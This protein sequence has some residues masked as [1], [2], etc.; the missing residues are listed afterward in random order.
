MNHVVLR[1]PGDRIAARFSRRT[2][3]VVLSLGVVLLASVFASLCL[4]SRATPPAAVLEA[5]LVPGDGARSFIVNELRLPRVVL[6]VLVGAAFAVAGL[7]LQALVRNPLASPD[8]IGVTGGGSVAAVVFLA[9]QGTAFPVHRL[10]PVA[11]TGAA[12]SA[13]L[14]VALAWQRGVTPTRLVLIGVG[15]AAAMGAVTTLVMVL[16]PDTTTL[17]AYVWLIGSLYAAQWREVQGIVPWFAL[18]LPVALFHA[19]HMDALALGDGVAAGLGVNVMRTRLVVLSASVVL[20]GAAVAFAGG[21]G[22]V[23][24][25]APHI[26]RRLTRG[27]SRVAD[28]PGCCWSP[29]WWAQ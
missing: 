17:Q 24:L 9:V 16:N 11:M 19:R 23:G 28:T 12:A 27:G 1:S 3:A 7:L 14:I 15:I 29:P 22:F 5:L 8:V 26:A 18:C 25:M 6:A 13:L 10:P 4:G 21:I 20:A 2:A